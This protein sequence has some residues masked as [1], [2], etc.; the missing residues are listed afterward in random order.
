MPPETTREFTCHGVTYVRSGSCHRCGSCEKPECPHLSW[1]NQGKALCGIHNRLGKKL[2]FCSDCQNDIDGIWGSR[3]LTVSITH[4]IC[5]DFPNHPF[6]RVI[7]DGICGYTFEPKTPED[8]V[9]HQ[10]LVD[11]WQWQ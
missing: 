4:M 7:R 6:L 8:A 1:D 9:K 5:F 10:K 2:Y 11:A 3:G